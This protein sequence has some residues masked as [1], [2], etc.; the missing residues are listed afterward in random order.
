MD[1]ARQYS[2]TTIALLS[3]CDIVGTTKC[4]VLVGCTALCGECNNLDKCDECAYDNMYKD[5]VEG[6]TTCHGESTCPYDCHI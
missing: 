3:L 2:Y 4:L 6:V 5:T 1:F